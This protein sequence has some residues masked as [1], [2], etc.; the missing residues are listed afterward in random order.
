MPR[1]RS[2]GRPAAAPN[3]PTVPARAAPTQQQRPATTMA[4]TPAQAPPAAAAP[5]ASAGPGLF[6]Q[7]ASTAAYVLTPLL[8]LFTLRL[9]LYCPVAT[10]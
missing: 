8:D 6:G 4:P 9:L 7:M 5:T 1:Q 3:R 2:A 10:F